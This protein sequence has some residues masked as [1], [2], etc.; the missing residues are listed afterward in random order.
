MTHSAAI[1]LCGFYLSRSGCPIMTVLSEMSV[2]WLL[3]KILLFQIAHYSEKM[4][5][6]IWDFNILK[7]GSAIKIYGYVATTGI[8]QIHGMQ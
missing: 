6:F 1:F 2:V 3:Q 4:F 5:T 7:S 8:V